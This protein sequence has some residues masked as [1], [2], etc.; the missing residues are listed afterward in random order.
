MFSAKKLLAASL[1]PSAPAAFALGAGD[2]AFT[3]L[4]ADEDGWTIVALTDVAANSTLYFT[5]SNWDGAAFTSNEGFHT[6]VSGDAGISAGTVIRFSDIDQAGRSV[7]IG[8]LT[9]TGNTALS[10]TAETLYAY[11]GIGASEPGTFLAAVSTESASAGAAAIAA[12]GLQSGVNALLLPASTD[13]SEYAG[14]RSGAADFAAY[15]ILIN[16]A[17]N[18]QGFTD[19]NHAD[20]QPQLGTFSV[21]AVPEP[22]AVAMLLTGIGVIALRRRR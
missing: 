4:N 18:W 8:S 6:W 14:A 9:S 13:Y 17:S 12:A 15:R 7:S 21:S 10:S 11:V 22:S 3:A 20:T 2:I 1:S 5:D 19:G 16:D